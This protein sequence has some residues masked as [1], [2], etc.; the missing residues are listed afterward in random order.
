MRAPSRYA[1]LAALALA[2]CVVSAGAAEADVRCARTINKEHGRYVRAVAKTMDKCLRSVL[3]KGQP[4]TLAECP[5][6]VDA[7]RIAV[8]A[9]KMRRKVETRCG[10]RNRT[11]GA[12]DAGPDADTPLAAIDWDIGRCMNFERGS[13]A[14]CDNVID[15]CGDVVDCL[16]CIADTAIDQ[17]IGKL[18]YERFNPQ[19]F[20]ASS[21]SVTRVQR[22]CLETVTKESLKFLDK[23]EKLLNKCWDSKLRGR[24]GFTGSD[25]CPDADPNL[26][27]SGQNKTVEKIRQLELRKIAAICKRCGGGADRD[28]DGVCDQVGAVVS[29]G[30][31]IGLDDIV[32][33]PFTCPPAVVPPSDLNPGGLDCGA[34]GSPAPNITTLQEYIDCI[35]CVMQFKGDCV[36]RSSVGDG[37]PAAGVTY[38][39][40]CNTCVAVASGP[41]PTTLQLTG[42]GPGADLDAGWTG[43]S[44][45]FSVPTN[46]RLTL[47]VSGCQGTERPSCGECTLAGPI[48][49]A[50]GTAFNNRR[51]S[52]DGTYVECTTDQ[53]CVD[54]GVTPPCVFFFG[55]P[56]PLSSGGVPVCVTNEVVG[57]VT[58]TI[59]VE[60]GEGET[61]LV[62]LV[63][64]VHTGTSV[65]RPCPVCR[66]DG[67]CSDGPRV[68][69]PCTVN[70]SVAEFGDV[71]FDCPP[72]TGGIIAELPIPLKSSTG[73]Q[74]RTLTAASPTCRAVGFSGSTCLCDTCNDA[75]ATPCTADADCPMSGG[76]PGVCGGRRCQGGTNNGNPC[77]TAAECPG[78]GTC[79][80][81]GLA[82]A[83]NQCDDAI[84]TP[85]TPPDGDSVDEG[86]CAAGPNDTVCSFERFRGCL[87]DNDC[88]PPPAGGCSDCVPGQ[89][90]VSRP[91]QCF[92]DNGVIGGTMTVAGS[93]EPFCG[94]S[95][96]AAIGALFCIGPTTST[97]AN[98][99]AG[100]PGPGR[101]TLGLRAVIDP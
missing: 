34:I 32:T 81:P 17:G 31:T 85:N 52:G 97:A 63:S 71:S 78:G 76:Q 22:R 51:C 74:T 47:A 6:A 2:G 101:L 68:G 56:L 13:F 83:P 48:P 46:A 12:A 91:R 36:A 62:N 20:F 41:C 5:T 7:G 50:G 19:Q 88:T 54:A 14:N 11:C 42:G 79:G 35:D 29:G 75:D 98:S 82:T 86:V 89:Q 67:T 18:L 21:G 73:V 37:N 95:A 44:H 16:Q 3:T 84:C 96:D 9:A 28:N 92:T 87:S 15:H 90:C 72:G 58:G 55:A 66:S 39:A 80:V 99:V 59:N 10:G 1:G 38:P 64:R 61:P 70:G 77:V 8:A 26:G 45:D 69:Q 24:P 23:K 100:I 60:T 65:A 33:L 53:D 40:E 30:V 27:P 93:A 25:P 4:A 94:N 57:T 43:L 49:N